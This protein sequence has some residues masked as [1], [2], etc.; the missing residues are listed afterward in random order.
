MACHPNPVF[1]PEQEARIRE[2]FS[3]ACMQVDAVAVQAIRDARAEQK[4]GDM[5]ADLLK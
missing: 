4:A 3:E 1:T 5:L 2:I